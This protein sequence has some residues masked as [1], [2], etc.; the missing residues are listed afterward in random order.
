MFLLQVLIGFYSTTY[1]YSISI[2]S[3]ISLRFSFG[4]TVIR[5]ALYHSEQT[6]NPTAFNALLIHDRRI[7]TKEKLGFRFTEHRNYLKCV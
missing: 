2:G 6:D 4:F 3:S 5:K 7:L 1:H